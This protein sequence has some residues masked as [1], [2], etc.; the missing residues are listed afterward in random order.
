V[1][2]PTVRRARHSVCLLH[3]RLV[4]VTKCQRAVF[5]DAMLT[6]WTMRAGCAELDVEL[7]EFNGEAVPAHLLV[8]YTP[9]LAICVL[10]QREDRTAYSVLREFTGTR[11]RPHMCGHLCSP[12][13]SAVSYCGARLSIIKQYIQGQ[14]QPL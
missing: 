4:S 6:F 14:A 2:T 10:A 1:T 7:V 8:A 9:T 11:V 12:T 13:Y 5:T 3:A